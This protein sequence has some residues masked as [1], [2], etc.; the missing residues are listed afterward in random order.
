MDTTH[1]ALAVFTVFILAL[2]ISS[3]ISEID[4]RH[5][6]TARYEICMGK[7]AFAECRAILSEE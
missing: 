7:H 5:E 4:Q 3:T 2:G 6:Q 1:A